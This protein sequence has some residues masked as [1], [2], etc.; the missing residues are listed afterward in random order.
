MEMPADPHPADQD[1]CSGNQAATCAIHRR[2][3]RGSPTTRT[4]RHPS[5]SRVSGLCG[6]SDPGDFRAVATVN[7]LLNMVAGYRCSAAGGSGGDPRQA[8]ATQPAGA[9]LFKPADVGAADD[10]LHPS[11]RGCLDQRRRAAA[12]IRTAAKLSGE[13]APSAPPDF[14]SAEPGPGAGRLAPFL[15]SA[16]PDQACPGCRRYSTG[17]IHQLATCLGQPLSPHSVEAAL[18]VSRGQATLQQYSPPRRTRWE[19]AQPPS[20]L[21]PVVAPVLCSH[22]TRGD[23]CAI[24]GVVGLGTGTETRSGSGIDQQRAPATHAIRAGTT[25]RD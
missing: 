16:G 21:K 2:A 17:E 18:P 19:S 15:E 20:W 22:S 11:Q 5:I 13:H 4:S 3:I 14:P 25:R 24:D 6:Q 10:K 23:S 8:V 12:P 1:A 7:W 9:D